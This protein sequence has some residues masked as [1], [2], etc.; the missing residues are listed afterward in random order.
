[1][2]YILAQSPGSKQS[3]KSKI[4]KSNIAT[5]LWTHIH[6]THW[7]AAHIKSLPRDWQLS[8]AFNVSGEVAAAW[9]E[10]E[11]QTYQLHSIEPL[12]DVWVCETHIQCL[13]KLK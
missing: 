12:P 1:M 9:L 8:Y 7:R 3:T 6:Q 5:N 11:M 2:I 13:L 10:H 4:T